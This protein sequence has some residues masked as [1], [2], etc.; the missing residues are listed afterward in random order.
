MRQQFSCKENIEMSQFGFEFLRRANQL[1]ASHEETPPDV[2]FNHAG[3]IILAGDLHITC[4][5]H[6]QLSVAR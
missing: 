2:Q 3:Y 1:L 5:I 6:F 4:I